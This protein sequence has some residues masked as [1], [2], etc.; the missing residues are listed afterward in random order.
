VQ[1]KARFANSGY[2]L[3]P[4][5]YVNVRLMLGQMPGALTVPQPAVQR[6]QQGPFVYVLDAQA[7][8][9]VRPVRIAVE[10]DGVSVIETGLRAGERV[11]V[12]GQYKLKPGMAVVEAP[13][14]TPASGPAAA[15]RR[16]P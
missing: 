7:Q 14:R 1:L 11:V 5:Q 4:G 13:A 2:A 12:S 16:L 9:Q 6:G 8:A 3:W 10:Q 15:A